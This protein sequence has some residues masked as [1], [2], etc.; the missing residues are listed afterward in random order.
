VLF[1]KYLYVLRPIIALCFI[2][3]QS[4]FPPTSFL[5]TL[6]GVRLEQEVLER[7]GE[8]IARKQAGEELGMGDADMVLNAFVEKHLARWDKSAFARYE[9]H[10]VT[11]QLNQIL[12]EIL[13]LSRLSDRK[14]GS[15]MDPRRE[16]GACRSPRE[17]TSRKHEQ[18]QP[19]QTC[20]IQS[21][22]LSGS[23]IGKV[24]ER[25]SACEASVLL[26]NFWVKQR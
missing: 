6:A 25:T 8:L 7:I 20:W 3:E 10:E 13:D 16:C 15:V 9:N 17:S 5:Q 11:Q 23:D 18:T 4:S 2:E 19:E 26:Y 1:K 24:Q 21:T 14:I 22:R 12:R